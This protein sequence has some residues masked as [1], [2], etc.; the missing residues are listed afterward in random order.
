MSKSPISERIKEALT[1][2]LALPF[3]KRSSLPAGSIPGIE[4]VPDLHLPPA[5]ATLSLE[6]ID[7]APDIHERRSFDDVAEALAA[8][9]NGA[10]RW[11]NINGLH[12]YVVNACRQA[13]DIHTLHAEDA[14]HV[15]QRPRL[16]AE[17]DYL[18]IITRMLMRQGNSLRS[19]QISI[20]LLADTLLTIQERKGDV[21]GPIR[22]RLETTGTRIRGQSPDF[23]AY[24]LLDAIVDYNFPLLE[25]YGD[26]LETLEDQIIESPDQSRIASLHAIKRD[27]LV[28]RRTI[29]PTR[30]LLD[31]LRRYEGHLLGEMAQR[32]LADVHE[33]V[34]QIIDVLESYR[35]MASSLTDL[36]MT[37][38]SNRMNEI[39]K[40]LTIMAAFFIPITFVAGVY[41]M[42]FEHMPEL[43]WPG[44]YPTF[45]V[46]IISITIG[47]YIS[48]KRRNWL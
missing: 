3:A 43:A 6:V 31:S 41:G 27:L 18:F 21:W 25:H 35:E 13:F 15:H 23:L 37:S 14:L 46:V 17:D 44:A 48:F 38:V 42:N 5:P 36:Y 8:P 33:H 10:V 22:E 40:V 11:I 34:I 20:F 2:P 12:P 1:S 32:Y 30:E 26:Q 39:M 24:A 29:W 47:L 7:Y 28:C 45:W 16:E 4:S 19:E 9:R